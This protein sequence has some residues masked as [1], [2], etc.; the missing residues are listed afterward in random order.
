MDLGKVVAKEGVLMTR[1][2]EDEKDFEECW[3]DCWNDWRAS[4]DIDGANIFIKKS[5]KE[6]RREAFLEGRRT[7]QKDLELMKYFQSNGKKMI[8]DLEDA[9]DKAET[10]IKELEKIIFD[11]VLK[12]HDGCQIYRD[13]EYTKLESKFYDAKARIKELEE[14][15]SDILG[16]STVSYVVE[17]RLEELI[18]KKGR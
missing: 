1:E 13:E 16:E 10:R 8:G 15:I 7:L 3:E 11:G 14:G 2:E 18:K 9:L 6:H 12:D 4:G 17:K 5:I